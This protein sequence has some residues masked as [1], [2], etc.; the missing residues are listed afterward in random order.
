MKHAILMTVYQSPELINRTLDKYASNFDFYIHIDKKSKLDIRSLRKYKNVTIIKKYKVNW[1]GFNHLRAYFALMKI[2]KSRRAYDYFHL[3]TGQDCILSKP[4]DF[5]NL[6]QGKSHMEWMPAEEIWG[7]ESVNQRYYQ[8]RFLDMFDIKRPFL[9]RWESRFSKILRR[10][11]VRRK[12]FKQK[13]YGGS[14]YCSFTREAVD[15]ILEH[16]RKL[17]RRLKYTF[18]PEEVYFQTLLINSPLRETIAKGNLRLINWTYG[19]SG[20]DIL[21]EKDYAEATSG[22]YLFGRKVDMRESASFLKALDS[23]G[24]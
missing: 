4:R 18:I 10:L 24:L 3:I 9:H 21:E 15:Y 23:A 20:P 19:N 13:L 5:D 2:A 16:G 14:T 22:K 1:G 12:E 17:N 11:K 8:F 6:L 7:I